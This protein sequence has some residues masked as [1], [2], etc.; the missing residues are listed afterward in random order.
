MGAQK[1]GCL[2]L[3][4]GNLLVLVGL[5]LLAEGLA[6]YW[7]A[8]REYQALRAA[9]DRQRDA[10]PQVAERR[11]TEYDPQLGWVNTPDAHVPDMYGPGKEVRINAQG[12]RADTPTTTNVA[13]GKVR[14][15]CSGD[16]FTLGYGVANDQTWC[17]Q[18]EQKDARLEVVNMGQGGYGIDQAYLWYARD[19]RPLEHDVHLFA[20]I[21]WDFDRMETDTVSGYGK[22]ILTLQNGRLEVRNTPVP[23]KASYATWASRYGGAFMRLRA[24]QLL[25]EWI[26]GRPASSA[27]GTDAG[28]TQPRRVDTPAV[29]AKIF[30]TLA[31]QDRAAGRILVVAFLPTEGDRK[32]NAGDVWRQMLRQFTQQHGILFIDLVDDFRRLPANAVPPLF[33]PAGALHYDHAAG[34]Y[35]EAGNAYIAD[36]LYRK[37]TAIPEVAARFDRVAAG[38]GAEPASGQVR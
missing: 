27:T 37:L 25:S 15:I 23:R 14:V 22:P 3:L 17:A 33:I 34:H 28:T 31:Q 35:T 5:L 13:P 2:K 12:F 18:L 6:G 19:G 8:W 9:A 26:L 4:A 10:P 20:I 11:H 21:K 24:P 16:S 38:P 1:P 32:P 29:C 36:L 7:T 30:E